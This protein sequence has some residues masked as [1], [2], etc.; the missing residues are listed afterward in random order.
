M[1]VV[2]AQQVAATQV[3]DDEPEGALGT[4]EPLDRR[5]RAEPG[6]GGSGAGRGA[7]SGSVRG[8]L[9]AARDFARVIS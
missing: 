2:D 4:F 8:S 7:V 6:T 9:R 3:S 5:A 1:A